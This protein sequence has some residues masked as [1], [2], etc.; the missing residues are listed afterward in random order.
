MDKRLN[1]IS[2]ESYEL[3]RAVLSMVEHTLNNQE[4]A[5][6]EWKNW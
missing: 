2:E 1:V 3:E 6:N 5:N 4:K